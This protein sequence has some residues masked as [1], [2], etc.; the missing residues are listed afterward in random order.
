MYTNIMIVWYMSYGLDFQ[1]LVRLFLQQLLAVEDDTKLSSCDDLARLTTVAPT[2]M[3]EKM[4]RNSAISLVPGLTLSHGVPS[5]P[6]TVPLE[7]DNRAVNT[8]SISV[9]E[10]SVSDHVRDDQQPGKSNGDEIAPAQDVSLS[11][12]GDGK[13]LD[14]INPFGDELDADM[15]SKEQINSKSAVR[16]QQQEPNQQQQELNQQQQEPNQQ[17][18]EPNQQQQLTGAADTFSV[19]QV[20][21]GGG[22][23]MGSLTARVVSPN[24]PASLLDTDLHVPLTPLSPDATLP[25]CQDNKEFTSL[26]AEALPVSLYDDQCK[27]G[28]SVLCEGSTNLVSTDNEVLPVGVEDTDPCG[29]GENLSTNMGMQPQTPSQHQAT[30]S[31]ALSSA[32]LSLKQRLREEGGEGGERAGKQEEREEGYKKA[33]KQDEFAAVREMMDLTAADLMIESQLLGAG[34]DEATV[35]SCSPVR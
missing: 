34:E 29:Q 25:S 8:N 19:V 9:D 24:A 22:Q 10:D 21:E 26:V 1:M 28:D 16:K 20:T 27:T 17:Q 6:T 31:R 15:E 33:G 11:V 18:E 30:P 7:A 32:E 2:D 3:E 5:P 13:N 23:Q 35:P 4:T 12:D 14:L